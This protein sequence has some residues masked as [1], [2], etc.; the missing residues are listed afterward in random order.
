MSALLETQA[1]VFGYEGAPLLPPISLRLSPGTITAVVGR[2]GSG[3]TT[4]LRTLLGLHS[5]LGGA[6]RRSEA[7]VPGYVPQRTALDPLVP[8]RVIDV[9]SLGADRGWDFF[10]GAGRRKRDRVLACLERV[11]MTAHLHQRFQSLSE[12]Q[13]QRVLLARLLAGQASVAFLDEP[14]AAMDAVA[15]AETMRL[16]DELRREHSLA[17]VLVSHDLPIVRTLADDVLFVDRDLHVALHGTPKAIFHSAP[18][19]ARYGTEPGR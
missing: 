14:T 8:L 3:K 18:F 19:L 13:K 7:F 15:E 1:L 5:P 12:G 17:V 9:V 10:P 2:N 4:L 11:G 6:V 16:I